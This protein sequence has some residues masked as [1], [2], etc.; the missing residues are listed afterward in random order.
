MS[1]PSSNHAR[2][3]LR[4]VHRMIVGASRTF[5]T[6]FPRRNMWNAVRCYV[7]EHRGIRH[8]QATP[9]GIR[10]RFPNEFALCARTVPA[11][12]SSLTWRRT[13]STVP[14]MATLTLARRRTRST[15]PSMATLARRWTTESFRGRSRSERGGW[16]RTFYNSVRKAVPRLL[17]KLDAIGRRGIEGVRR[18]SS[19]ALD[20]SRDSCNHLGDR[21]LDSQV[22]RRGN[23]VERVGED[24]LDVHFIGTQ[25]EDGLENSIRISKDPEQELSLERLLLTVEPISELLIVKAISE[26]VSHGMEQGA[27][28]LSHRRIEVDE[29]IRIQSQIGL[30]NLN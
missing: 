7:T 2:I 18:H 15:V 23:L 22:R 5:H 26:L 4:E 9:R 27:I 19:R 12:T 10:R 13:R 8:H 29:S 1:V 11:W 3:P 28:S 17:L 21:V 25:L 30:E 6:A 24:S 16:S 14:A 20:E